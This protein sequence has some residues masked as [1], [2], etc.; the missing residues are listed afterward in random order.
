MARN[1]T[2][3]GMTLVELT[4]VLAVIAI[5]STL[6]VTFVLM[7][8][9]ESR[10]ASARLNAL[11]EIEL[12]ESLT[13]TWLEDNPDAKLNNDPESDG[14]R[15]VVESLDKS[16]NITLTKSVDGTVAYGYK[17]GGSTSSITLEQITGLTV[18]VTESTD[19]DSVDKLFVCT[20]TYEAGGATESYVFCVDPHK[21]DK[22]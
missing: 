22:A 20:L 2:K 14:V 7:L 21:G 10:L 4:V 6:V 19:A 17:N 12:V 5:V 13:E 18:K 15:I 16:D 1:E 11:E 9:E 3:R 8:S